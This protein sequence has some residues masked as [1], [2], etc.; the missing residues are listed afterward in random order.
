MPVKRLLLIDD[1]VGSGA[2]MNEIA[3]KI[4]QKGLSDAV[5]GVAITGSYKGFEV[6]SEL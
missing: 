6:I 5:L 3:L 4:K 2:T 1:A